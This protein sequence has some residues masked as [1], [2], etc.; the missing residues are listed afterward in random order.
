MEG[1]IDYRDVIVGWMADIFVP[2]CRRIH[3]EMSRQHSPIFWQR[4]PGSASFKQINDFLVDTFA[5]LMDVAAVEARH[6]STDA[7][8]RSSDAIRLRLED[9]IN[10]I[11]AAN[12][13]A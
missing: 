6:R 3:R 8:R 4:D 11:L 10:D 1:L 2:V 9:D 12:K 13:V 7:M 5:H